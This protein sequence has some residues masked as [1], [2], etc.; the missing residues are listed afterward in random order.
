MKIQA[1]QLISVDISTDEQRRIA[2]E[3]LEKKF[4]WN[5]NYFVEEGK[6]Y[7]MVE[8]VTSHRWDSKEL[9][10]EAKQTDKLMYQVFKELAHNL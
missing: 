10:R 7:Q 4:N 5:P 6:V 1:T 8:Y 2:V 3:F 9:V